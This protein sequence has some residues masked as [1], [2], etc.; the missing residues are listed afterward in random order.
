METNKGDDENPNIRSML[1]ARE[2]RMAGQD[3]ILVGRTPFWLARTHFGW[4]DAVLA[5]HSFLAG[6]DVSL[7]GQ[8]PNLAGPDA[9]LTGHDVTPACQLDRTSFWLAR[10]PFQL[11]RTPTWLA[12]IPFWLAWTPFWL[13]MMPL[14]AIGL[15]GHES[16]V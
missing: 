16:G 4:S 8:Y 2:I 13:A 14:W 3:A 5:G 11:A 9:I 12:E 7:A 6:R 1:V 10:T 15:A